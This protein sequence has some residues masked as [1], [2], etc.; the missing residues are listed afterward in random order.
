MA[1]SVLSKE[2]AARDRGRRKSDVGLEAYGITQASN[3]Y[4]NLTASS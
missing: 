2:S 4:W 1:A 3:V